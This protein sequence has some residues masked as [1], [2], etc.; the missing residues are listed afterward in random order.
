MKCPKCGGKS[1]VIDTRHN[2]TKTFRKLK[3]IECGNLYFTKEEVTEYREI[4]TDWRANE[5]KKKCW[6]SKI[7]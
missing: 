3:C 4:V 2:N 1:K 7:I 6:I 5:R